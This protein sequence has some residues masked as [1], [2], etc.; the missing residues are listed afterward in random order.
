MG[1]NNATR[2]TDARGRILRPGESVRQDGRYAYKYTG[3]DGK[4]KFIYSWRLNETDPLPKGKKP[5]KSLREMK[6]EILAMEQW[7]ANDRR[8]GLPETKI[9]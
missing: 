1:K 9:I 4:P 2:R 3:T 6:K 8:R 5:C 7:I